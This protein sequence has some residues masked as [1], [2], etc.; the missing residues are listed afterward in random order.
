MRP[1]AAH[2]HT[3]AISGHLLRNSEADEAITL[4]RRRVCPGRDFCM[5][6]QRPGTRVL[7]GASLGISKQMARNRVDK[8]RRSCFPAHDGGA[9]GCRRMRETQAAGRDRGL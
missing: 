4:N 3:N 8:L 5:I 7:K 6:L 9:T 1:A 2:T